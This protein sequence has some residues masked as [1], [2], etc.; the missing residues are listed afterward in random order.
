MTTIDYKYV[1]GTFEECDV[2]CRLN[3]GEFYGKLLNHIKENG[4][5][6]DIIMYAVD[7]LRD[8]VDW[9]AGDEMWDA[10]DVGIYKT[11]GKHTWEWEEESEEEE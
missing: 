11:T 2:E 5:M 9:T 4:L 1:F 7:D 10:L 6:D 3:E 8:W